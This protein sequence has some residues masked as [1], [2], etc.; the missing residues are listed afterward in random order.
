MRKKEADL[1]RGGWNLTCQM[2]KYHF[3]KT[4]TDP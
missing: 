4:E 3:K 2:T 1:P